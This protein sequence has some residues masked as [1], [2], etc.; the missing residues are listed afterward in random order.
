MG[1]F[2]LQWFRTNMAH[3]P[4]HEQL[5]IFYVMPFLGLLRRWN[6]VSIFRAA[7]LQLSHQCCVI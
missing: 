4:L 2:G 7:L 1:E 6:P 3:G 5:F